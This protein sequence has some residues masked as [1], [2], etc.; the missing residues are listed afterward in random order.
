MAAGQRG[1]S[2]MLLKSGG[3]GKMNT[4]LQKYFRRNAL[5]L[6]RGVTTKEHAVGCVARTGLGFAGLGLRRALI[7]LKCGFPFPS[8]RRRVPAECA[9]I[10]E[11]TSGQQMRT[12]R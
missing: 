3:M 8:H 10:S 4:T 1:D 2:F 9:K 12:L 11:A 5:C 7:S 6:V